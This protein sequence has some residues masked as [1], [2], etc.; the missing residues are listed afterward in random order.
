M[1]IRWNK[2][3][4]VLFL[5]AVNVSFSQE[6]NPTVYPYGGV[7]DSSRFKDWMERIPLNF[8]KAYFRNAQFDSLADFRKAKFDSRADLDGAKFYGRAD[9]EK[10]QFHSQAGFALA[11]FDS[12]ADFRVAQ[13]HSW[14][15]FVGTQFAGRA[16]F[17]AAQFAGRADFTRA[18][19]DSRADFRGTQ[20]DS[21]PDFERAHIESEFFVGSREGQK[22]DFNRSIFSKQSKII[23]CELAE[24]NIQ[25]EKI[26]HI[27]L[28]DTLSYNLKRLIIENLKDKSFKE[29]S[30]AQFEL[31]Y[32]FDKSTMYQEKRDE[33][34]KNK[35]YQIWKYPK[36]FLNTLYYITM[37]LGYRPF[38]L[39]WWVLGFII[40]FGIFYF[41]K[42]R[43]SI[44]GYILKKFEMKESS[45]TKRKKAVDEVSTISRTESLM[46][47]LY[48]SSMLLFSFRLKGE[49]LT[50]FNLKEKRFIVGE[51]L[52]G[53][54]IY[55]AF[56]TLAKSGSILHNLRSLFVG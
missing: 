25:T 11:K 52:L 13:F 28:L 53:L 29:N 30:K 38:R 9:F 10:A 27:F 32:I 12:L 55:I 36:W 45:G 37:G 14:V 8:K 49:I 33:Y 6:N 54:L 22:F 56:L 43:D 26:K 7:P 4:I 46:N 34:I 24:I 41:F 42:M 2:F 3:L 18:N 23:L 15:Y 44:N 17:L 19:F 51:Y 21:L 40:S 50:F 20:F 48:F 1:P 16:D 47:C 35:W 31:E 5:L 39:A